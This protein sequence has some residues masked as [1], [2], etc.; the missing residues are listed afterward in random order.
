MAGLFNLAADRAL[1]M[2]QPRPPKISI[3]IGIGQPLMGMAGGGGLSSVQ[4]KMNIG[5]EPHKLAYINA[6]EASLL[7][8]LGGSGRPVNGVPAYYMGD[9]PGSTG[10]GE[11]SSPASETDPGTTDVDEP[12]GYSAL[13]EGRSADVSM[14][15]Q[16]AAAA[17]DYATSQEFDPSAYSQGISS[18]TDDEGK[19]GLLGLGILTPE[20]FQNFLGRLGAGALGSVV[21]GPL[22]GFIGYQY[23]P[24]MYEWAKKEGHLD[25][26]PDLDFKGDPES[27][28]FKDTIDEFPTEPDPEDEEEEEEVEDEEEED[29]ELTG[30]ARYWADKKARGRRDPYE[31]YEYILEDVYGKDWQ[32]RLKEG[33]I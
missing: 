31:G 15:A 20:N 26:M 11:A 32:D 28:D 16:Q 10:F 4:K 3:A 1:H 30:M 25:W 5:G 21:G 13:G 27:P 2:S 9:E 7:K 22:G 19:G 29:E 6:D 24:E 14:A 18:L 17:A 12:G 23:G 33:I 8:Q